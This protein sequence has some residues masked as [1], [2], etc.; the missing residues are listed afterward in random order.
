MHE[1]T[2]AVTRIRGAKNDDWI[3]EGLAEYY[4]IE[5]PRRA[6]LLSASRFEKALAWMKRF[7]SGVDHLRVRHSTGAITAR[8]VV[9]LH[10]LDREIAA[11]TNGNANIDAVV[12]RA[13]PDARGL[14]RR[15]ARGRASACFGAPSQV[16]QFAAARGGRALSR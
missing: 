5:L 9:L 1:L 16:L 3:A 15:S 13:D 7:G 4:S 12:A 14:A 8:A 2:H 6:G 11:K 10:E